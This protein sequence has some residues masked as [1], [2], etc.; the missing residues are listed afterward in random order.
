MYP[1]NSLTEKLK[2]SHLEYDTH[3]SKIQRASS[4]SHKTNF[5]NLGGYKD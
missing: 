2:V 3:L 5:T 4:F 1:S